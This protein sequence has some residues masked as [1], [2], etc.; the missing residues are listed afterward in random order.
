MIYTWDQA[1]NRIEITRDAFGE[2]TESAKRAAEAG[3]ELG[4]A[5]SSAFE[6]AV[7][8]GRKVRDMVR[9]LA[10]D[11]AR[12]ALRQLVTQPM[13]N[14]ISGALASAFGG[15]G[16]SM[17]GAA[18]T[19]VPGYASGTDYVPRT[20]LAL[21]HQGERITPAGQNGGGVTIVQNL[22]V[23]AETPLAMREVV[24]SLMPQ[25]GQMAVRAVMDAKARGAG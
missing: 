10:Q 3:K 20:G 8:E 19:G 15:A 23:S 1:G 7:I 5:F 16:G 17:A 22:N 21:V 4:W 2:L 9:G 25:I 6:N 14:A 18:V 12:I 24:F 11:I 13:A